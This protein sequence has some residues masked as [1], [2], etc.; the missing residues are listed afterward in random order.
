MEN[1]NDLTGIIKYLHDNIGVESIKFT[2]ELS[3]KKSV[4]PTTSAEL[5][6]E[7]ES[8]TKTIQTGAGSVTLVKTESGNWKPME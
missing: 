7:P 8:E 2:A 1:S 6:Q 4:E 3:L 5:T